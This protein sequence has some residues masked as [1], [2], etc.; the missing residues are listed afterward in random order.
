MAANTSQ[1]PRFNHTER[2]RVLQ[3][4][5]EILVRAERIQETLYVVARRAGTLPT[6]WSDEQLD[7]LCDAVR[8]LARAAERAPLSGD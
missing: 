2:A 7:R 5:D 8:A 6:T 3:E 1:R 4:L